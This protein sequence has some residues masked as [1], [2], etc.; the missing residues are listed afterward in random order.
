MNARP[1][2]I[3]MIDELPPDGAE[4]LI[5]DVL[6]K[7]SDAYDYR[8][9][10]LVRGGELQQDIELLGVPVDI[11][12]KRVGFDRLLIPRLV[13][14]LKQENVRVVHTHLFTADFWGRLAAWIARVPVIVSTSHSENNWKTSL[15]RFLDQLMARVSHT[16]VACTD[17]VKQVLLDRDGISE[18]KITL[19][20][21]GINLE[22]FSSSERCDLNAEFGI[23][24]ESCTL[25]I[26]GRFHPVKGHLYFLNVF[27]KL[28]S[29][30]PVHLLLVGDGELRG[31]IEQRIVEL[32][33]Q[34]NVTLAGF[35]R[36]VPAILNSV[37]LV[38]VPSELEGLPMV[39][40]EAMARGRAVVA[41]RVGGIAD[42][43]ENDSLG[44]MVT[45]GDEAEMLHALA[46]LADDADE[47]NTIGTHSAALIRS[48]YDAEDTCRHYEAIY[49]QGLN[50]G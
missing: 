25:A 24:P 40:L 44:R 7:R 5:V 8:V 27:A 41:H 29:A 46:E 31:A 21:N 12:G 1:V 43:I 20:A 13:R 28:K 23:P 45:A 35:R 10:C 47:R 15:H 37:D 17:K 6:S 30:T 19:V 3:H 50:A 2:V 16:V 9:L 11:L 26:V 32:G 36:D 42:V 22:R 48:K 38:V 49:E 33:L 18:S 39:V 14:Y 4:R 34:S